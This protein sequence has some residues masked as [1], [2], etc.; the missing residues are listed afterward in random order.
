MPVSNKD[1]VRL[2]VA[3]CGPVTRA[4]IANELYVQSVDVG[5][6]W[7][8]AYLEA[9]NEIRDLRDSGTIE[10]YDDEETDS[11]FIAYVTV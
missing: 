10:P 9:D 2:Y 4:Q 8:K 6:D 11:T 1:I 7:E 3:A 5:K